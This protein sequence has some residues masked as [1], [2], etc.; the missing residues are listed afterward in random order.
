M[1]DERGSI[2][3]AVLT[4]VLTTACGAPP[5]AKSTPAAKV[6]AGVT[7]A[8]LTTITLTADAT[9]RLGI[10]TAAIEQRGV[11]RTRTVGGEVTAPGAAQSTVTAPFAGT[12]EA[13]IGANRIGTSVEQGA[14][15][16]RLVPLAASD[17][18]ARVEA[19]RALDEA[20]GRQTQ[21]TQRAERAARLASNGAGSRRAA[22]DAQGDLVVANAALKAAQERLRLASRGV[23]ASGALALA[24]P[25]S[26]VLQGLHVTPGQPVT[27][28]APLFDVVRL[29]SVW[30]RVPLFAGDIEQVDRRA[31]AR[32][33]ALGASGSA[34]GTAAEPVPA[35]PSADAATAAV[36]LYYAL[37]NAGGALRPGQRVSVRL[38]LVAGSQ[39]LV[40][41]GAAILHDSYGGTWVYEARDAHVFV[42][43]RVSVVDVVGPLAVLDRGPLAGTRVVTTG[44]AEL[45]GTEFG[46]GK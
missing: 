7:E 46:V 41:P 36:D 8:S 26:A 37:A 44:A 16:V 30:I 6:T 31:Q 4:A 13:T 34:P 42:R 22:E 35:P 21:A 27:S 20:E 12:V 17:R 40:A 38:P 1:A 29:D 33:V 15:I 25:I 43:R 39:S 2:V 45:F 5:P 3:A 9:R 11:A 19:Q 14:V 23:N 18:D 10:E 32:V 28:G 24:A